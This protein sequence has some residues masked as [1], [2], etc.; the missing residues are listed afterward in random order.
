MASPLEKLFITTL[1]I[2]YETIEH[3]QRFLLTILGAI[4]FQVERWCNI[5]PS[6]H[7]TNVN[8]TF[9]NAVGAFSKCC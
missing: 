6:L 2:N 4:Y 8:K 9:I 5:T 1:C 7:E 3:L